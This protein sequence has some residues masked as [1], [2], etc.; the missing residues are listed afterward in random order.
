[1]QLN[2]LEAVRPLPADECSL[3]LLT[4]EYY[5]KLMVLGVRG[6]VS[7]SVSLRNTLQITKVTQQKFSGKQIYIACES[8]I[9]VITENKLTLNKNVRSYVP[10]MC[11][12]IRLRS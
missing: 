6:W 7:N 5:I 4:L 1:V 9:V 2:K 8:Y 11:L 12:D 10:F 3:T